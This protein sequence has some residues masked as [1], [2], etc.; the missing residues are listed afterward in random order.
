MLFKSVQMKAISQSSLKANKLTAS[1]FKPV[2][3][4]DISDKMTI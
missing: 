1:Y 4:G 2:S 3:M